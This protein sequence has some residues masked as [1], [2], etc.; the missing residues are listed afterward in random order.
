[1]QERC[2]SIANALELNISCINPLRD[3][4]EVKGID[5]SLLRKIS[6]LQA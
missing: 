4:Q 6:I 2:N 5:F 3:D 1:M